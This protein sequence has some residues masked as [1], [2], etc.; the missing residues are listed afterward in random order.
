MTDSSLAEEVEQAVVLCGG[1]GERLR[2]L[3]DSLPKPMADIGGRPFLEHLLGQLA[4]QG[5]RRFTL[6]TGYLGST[7]RDHFEDGR[8][9]GWSISYGAGPTEWDTGRRVIEA[10]DLLDPSFLLLYGDNYAGVDLRF[11]MQRHLELGAVVT[12]HL[13]RKPDGNIRMD[14]DGG[15]ETYDPS[16]M[17]PGLDRVEV[18]YML[19][20]RDPLLANLGGLPGA[21][22]L[23]LSVAIQDLAARGQLA[24][25]SIRGLYES[26]SDPI[27]LERTRQVLGV[28]KILLLDRDG[29][30][31]HKAPPGEYVTTWEEFRW[32]DGAREALV[33][34]ADDG[35][36]F[37]VITNQAGIAR[38]MVQPEELRRIHRNLVGE[39]GELGVV[40]EKIYVSP[41]HWEDGSY[42]RKP[43]PGLLLRAADEFCFML[44]RV[45]YVGDDLRDVE[46]A[47]N[48][49]CGM[50]FIT[51]DP[52]PVGFDD[53][54]GLRHA[55]ATLGGMVSRIREHYREV[56]DW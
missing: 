11:L 5:V 54:P 52:L 8:R 53:G 25:V 49:G 13:A 28:R 43:E 17:S 41:H 31:N 16:R 47:T 56:A 18:G 24:A 42:D 55:C 34:L 15:V 35:F 50:A 39:L 14:G 30:L 38:G 36:S 26:V 12:L 7:I 27:R 10:R 29:T 45:V 46:V 23:S 3:T 51:S 44:E 6:L 32:V 48:A 22:D 19:V 2:P 33:E 4:R 20:D 37:I 1:R 40:I 9:W 21:P